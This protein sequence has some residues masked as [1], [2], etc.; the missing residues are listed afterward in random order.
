M[1]KKMYIAV[2]SN[3]TNQGALVTRL[4]S[5]QHSHFL[6]GLRSLHS[7]HFSYSKRE[8][9]SEEEVRS[10]LYRYLDVNGST[11]ARIQTP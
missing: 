2:C 8:S 4:L 9:N 5:Y 7:R 11:S 10:G 6:F 3:I 1:T